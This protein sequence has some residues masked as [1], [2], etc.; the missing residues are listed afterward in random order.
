MKSHSRVIVLALA[1]VGPLTIVSARAQKADSLTK[2]QSQGSIAATPADT[3]THKKHGLFGKLKSVAENKTVQNVTKAAVCQALPGG[4]YMVAA[5]EAAK[6]KKSIASGVAGA[7]SCIP[8]MGG[9]GGMSPLGGKGLAGASVAGAAS[10]AGAA[11]ALGGLGGLSAAQA[12]AGGM[13]GVPNGAAI[14]AS[15]Q[16]LAG[17]QTAMAQMKASSSASGAAGG[18]ATTEASGQQMKLSGA[19]ADE[20]KKGKLVIKKID[21]VHGSAS[22]SA[23]STQGFSDLML[24]AGQAMKAAAGTYRVDVYMDKKY[25]DQEIATLGAQRTTVVVSSLQ[26]GGQ[27]GE[28]VLPGKIGKDKE[29][30]V[31]IVK[32]K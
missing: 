8:G 11:G 12:A 10:A 27:L 29:Q 9:M 25:S 23:P 26:A 32:V 16:G 2:V 6:D 19:V 24:S 14:S 30:R 13:H 20:I 3:T 17:M 31:E 1:I 18:E 21:W 7:Q 4:Q 5:A 28:A 15:A 22:V